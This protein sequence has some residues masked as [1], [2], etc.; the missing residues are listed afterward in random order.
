MAGT[1][2]LGHELRVNLVEA[3]LPPVA[4]GIEIPDFGPIA[5]MF[6]A[7]DELNVRVIPDFI[8]RQLYINILSMLYGM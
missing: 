6:L 3:K 2:M 4:R 8:E 5:D 7:D 1:D